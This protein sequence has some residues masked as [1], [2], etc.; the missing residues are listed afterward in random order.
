MSFYMVCVLYMGMMDQPVIRYAKG[1]ELSLKISAGLWVNKS[2]Y[3]YCIVG[4]KLY[5]RSKR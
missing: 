2:K 3:G 4:D 5:T 1:S